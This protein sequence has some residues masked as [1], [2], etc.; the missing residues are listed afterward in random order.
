[1]ILAVVLALAAQANPEAEIVMDRKRRE[2]A[3]TRNAETKTLSKPAFTQPPEMQQKFNACLDAAIDS[4]EA[5]A[6]WAE[7]SEE[8]TSELPSLMRISYAVLC[9]KKKNNTRHIYI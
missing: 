8:H 2:A 6:K 7:R 1:M 3:E 5:G 4:P 9:L